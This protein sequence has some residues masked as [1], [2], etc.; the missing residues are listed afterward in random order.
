MG[1]MLNHPENIYKLITPTALAY[2]IPSDLVVVYVRAPH[3]WGPFGHPIFV[4]IPSLFK[5]LRKYGRLWLDK[6]IS[7]LRFLAEIT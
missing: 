6:M 5:R 1:K 4:L 7:I 2:W 3:V